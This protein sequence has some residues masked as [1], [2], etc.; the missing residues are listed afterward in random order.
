MIS[1]IAAMTENRV[2]GR[3]N[4]LPWR[5]PAD[6]QH[7]KQLTLGK[8]ILMGRKTFDS[9]GRP[10]P[11]REN[12]VVTR[13]RHFHPAGVTVAH[14][15]DEALSGIPADTEVMIIGGASF[16]A[17]MIDRAD[18]IYLTIVHT[19][20]IEGDAFFPPVDP[21]RWQETAR[22]DFPPDARHAFAYS[23]VIFDRKHP[24]TGDGSIV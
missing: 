14:T 8:P 4:R 21:N 5:L 23:F 12:I 6:L 16:Y 1:L 22:E 18:R 2:I 3:N 24:L 7:F 20:D 10:L 17:Q 11:G 15:I 19:R 13:D 9:L